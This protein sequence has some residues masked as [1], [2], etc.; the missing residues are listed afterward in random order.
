[1][2]KILERLALPPLLTFA[3]LISLSLSPL[4]CE[5]G[6]VDLQGGSAAQ[7]LRPSRRG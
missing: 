6:E 5:E 4:G 1:M 7:S 3:A 2:I